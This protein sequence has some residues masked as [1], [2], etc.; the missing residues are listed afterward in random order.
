MKKALIFTA[1]FALLGCDKVVVVKRGEPHQAVEQASCTT[2]GWCMTCMPGINNM[3]MECSF[4]P[5]LYCPGTRRVL[6]EITPVIEMHESGASS[7]REDAIEIKEL[8]A[9]HL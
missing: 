6:V 1:M 3:K 8:E 5:S 7:T 9:C 4:K 2:F